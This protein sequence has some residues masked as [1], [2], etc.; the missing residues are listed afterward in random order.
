M[1]GKRVLKKLPK[2]GVL[3]TYFTALFSV[4]LSCTLLLGTT[5]AWLTGSSSS[6]GNRIRTGKLGVQLAHVVGDGSVAVLGQTGLHPVF[7]GDVT[8]TPGR[9]EIE[10]VRVTNTGTLALSYEL[11][12]ASGQQTRANAS[13]LTDLFTVYVKAGTAA[14][15][16]NPETASGWTPL[17]TLTHVIDDSEVLLSEGI[18]EDPGDR[19]TVSIA[20]KLS[21]SVAS[22]PGAMGQS[23]TVNLKL[24]AVQK[25]QPTGG[26]NS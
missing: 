7:S 17:G 1:K 5:Y 26:T 20:L 4:V 13:G 10:T 15:D 6:A 8:W 18:L 12:F 2:S 24:D 19:Q 22:M 23:L 11:D 16:E 21:E 3:G 9:T 25:T 14:A